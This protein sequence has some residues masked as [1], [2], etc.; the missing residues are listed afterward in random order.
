MLTKEQ[1]NLLLHFNP[2]CMSVTDLKI[3]RKA[4]QDFPEEAA[5]FMFPCES[6]GAS[7]ITTLL[8]YVKYKLYAMEARLEG[9][10]IAAMHEEEGADAAFNALPPYAKW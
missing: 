8:W 5:K 6:G 7:T 3:C 2:D 9:N 4:F 10:V 1:I